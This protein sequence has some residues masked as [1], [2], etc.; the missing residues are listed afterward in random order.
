MGE[1]ID[2]DQARREAWV[3]KLH[4]MRELGS[5]AVFGAIGEQDAVVLQFPEQ[6]PAPP[7]GAA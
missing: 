2:L 4:E 5:V 6:R 7:Q 3:R 1:V